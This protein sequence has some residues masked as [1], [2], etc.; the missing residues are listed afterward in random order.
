M[1]CLRLE[2]DSKFT[3]FC[4]RQETVSK[5]TVFCRDPQESV[6]DDEGLGTASSFESGAADDAKR[7]YEAMKVQKLQTRKGKFM[8]CTFLFVK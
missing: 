4:L 6:E 3:V 7:M 8:L 2:T 1:F 5:F